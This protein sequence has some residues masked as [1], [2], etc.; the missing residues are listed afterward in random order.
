MGCCVALKTVI[1]ES[2]INA[3]ILRP[4]LVQQFPFLSYTTEKR[5]CCR[6]PT[7]IVPDYERIKLA[8]ASMSAEQRSAFKSAIGAE[9][10]S[11]YCNENGKIRSVE[12]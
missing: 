5:G 7:Q 10:V 1:D 8:I 4:E 2:K 12:F 9:T 6:S 3:L 11:V